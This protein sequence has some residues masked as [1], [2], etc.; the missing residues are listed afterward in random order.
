MNLLHKFSYFYYPSP[1]E[2]DIFKRVFIWLHI[3]KY[4]MKQVALEGFLK[5]K[6]QKHRHVSKT[7]ETSNIELFVVLVISFQPLTNFT[8]NS[9]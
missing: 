2:R 4:I 7:I 1:F 9:T 5:K 6:Q 8:K 3:L